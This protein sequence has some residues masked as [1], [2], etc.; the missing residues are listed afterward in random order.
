MISV[1]IP[2]LNERNGIVETIARAKS[3]LDRAELAPY[4]IIVV[5]DGS[6]DGTGALAEQA[7]AKVL[8]HAHNIGY[9]RSLKDGIR[10][11]AY[12]TIVISDA[13]GSYPM[14][15][16]PALIA[17]LNEGFDM[18]VGARTGPN[19][20]ESM[21]KSPLR[22]VLK[23]IVEFTANR[24]IPDINSGLRVFQR[25]IAISYFEHVSDLFS[26]TTSLTL[27][28]M[29]NAKFVDYIDIDYKERIGRSKV[30]LFRDSLR[31]LQYVLEACTY[32]NPLK[33]F[34]LLAMMCMALA[35]V[36]LIGGI[37]LQV[38]SG[39]V[40]GVGAI[41]LSI[42]VVAMGLLAVLLKQIMNQRP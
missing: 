34:V 10:I 36:S 17:R 15:A 14:E 35:V 2:A 29:M 22:A 28:Y 23:T 42:L 37:I 40:L 11:A 7:G 32:Y 39:F 9:G 33:I 21:L 41:L 20:R 18:V 1:V 4:E 25:H 24:E 27:A 12:D 19:Y 5:D 38:V 8:R 3:V 31:T 16:I 6:N 26:F 13:D 30:N